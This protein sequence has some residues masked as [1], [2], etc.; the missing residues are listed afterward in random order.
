M[1]IIGTDGWRQRAVK[2]NF[3]LAFSLKQKTDDILKYDAQCCNVPKAFLNSGR[4]K[5]PPYV[6]LS[7][8]RLLR[9]DLG[10]DSINGK[11]KLWKWKRLVPAALAPEFSFVF[12]FPPFSSWK[13]LSN[14][15]ICCPT[16][17]NRSKTGQLI[18]IHPLGNA[19]PISNPP[20][21]NPK[22]FS[23]LSRSGML[24]SVLPTESHGDVSLWPGAG[25]GADQGAVPT[26]VLNQCG[27]SS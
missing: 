17:L 5:N 10:Q 21:W 6:P 20:Q 26:W 13:V 22:E 2:T 16:C 12:Y 18:Y 25:L 15:L 3:S 27:I 19:D 9:K 23:C 1:G 4:K 7:T 24:P 11:P 8:C 14:G